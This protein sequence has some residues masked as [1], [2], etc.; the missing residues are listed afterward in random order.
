MIFPF[1]VG[2]FIISPGVIFEAP[3][4]VWDDLFIGLFAEPRLGKASSFEV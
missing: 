1:V 2:Y 3:V 4:L